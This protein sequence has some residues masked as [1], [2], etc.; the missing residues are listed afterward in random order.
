ATFVFNLNANMQGILDFSGTLIDN[1]DSKKIYTIGRNIH[2]SYHVPSKGNITITSMDL[3]KYAYDTTPDDVFNKNVMDLS[4]REQ[5]LK[6]SKIHNAYLVS[7][8]YTVVT[9][10]VDY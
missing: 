4:A 9:T 7:T 2:F 3:H 1:R 8:P 6:I 5:N 10:C